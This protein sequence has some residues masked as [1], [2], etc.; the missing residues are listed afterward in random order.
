MISEKEIEILDTAVWIFG[1]S[2][3]S[4]GGLVGQVTK[5]KC[6]ETI[7]YVRENVRAV[8]S[9]QVSSGERWGDKNGT[10][11]PRRSRWNLDLL[12]PDLYWDEFAKLVHENDGLKRPVM[13]ARDFTWEWAESQFG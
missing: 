13:K 11:K 6:N 12:A 7:F 10:G 3:M 2:N 8:P 5:C 1:Q 4:S 9:F